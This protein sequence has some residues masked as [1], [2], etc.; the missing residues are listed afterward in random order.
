MKHVVSFALITMTFLSQAAAAD[1]C[2]ANELICKAARNQDRSLFVRDRCRYQQTIRVERFRLKGDEEKLEEVRETSVMVEPADNPDKT[3]QTPVDVRVIADTDKYGNPKRNVNEDDKTLLSFGAVWDL[4]FFPLV[5]E[6]IKYYTFQEVVADRRNEKWFRFV[7]RPE[8]TD[9]PLASGIAMLD[10][11]TGEVLT[12]R[13]EGLHNLEVLDKNAR[14]MR[15]F[16]ATIDY[17]QFQD[18]LRMPTLASG[19]GVSEISRFTGT[20]RFRFEEGR[21]LIVRK[22][23]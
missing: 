18:V 4:A 12:I 21:Y 1:D 11:Q 9:Q 8:V 22:I 3:G 5:P 16:H 7:P 23:D 15:S 20:F 6:R 14:K 19:G 17:S 13:I 2:T 10:P